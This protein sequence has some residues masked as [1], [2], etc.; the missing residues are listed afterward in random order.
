MATGMRDIGTLAGAFATIA[1]CCHSLNNRNEV[2]GFSI[3]ANGPTAFLWRDKVITD[4][5]ALIP[6]NSP[7]HLLFAE[8]I[9]DAGE[10]VGQGCV[11]PECTVL[12]AFRAISRTER[13]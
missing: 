3:G 5:N 9:N 4:L 11:L 7:L 13:R 2:V 12:H 1:P 6:A 10:I 8:S